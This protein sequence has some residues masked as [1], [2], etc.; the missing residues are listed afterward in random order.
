MLSYAL[1]LVVSR[2]N[3]MF[4]IGLTV[5][6][7]KLIGFSLQ[8]LV[9]HVAPVEDHK[10][11]NLDLVTTAQTVLEEPFKFPDGLFLPVGTRIGFLTK[12]IQGSYVGFTDPKEFN[13]HRFVAIKAPDSSVTATSD[14][15]RW[16]A[17][18][19]D[20]SSLVSSTT[21]TIYQ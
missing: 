21:I 5:L 1:F 8:T 2:Y 20:L 9:C 14:H 11:L 17:S 10:R 4:R 7:A 6:F 3:S 13:R 18:S 19:V 16:A 15:K 12:A